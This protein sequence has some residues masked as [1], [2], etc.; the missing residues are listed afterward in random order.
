MEFGQ[1]S[2]SDFGLELK[3]AC[4][5]GGSTDAGR[6]SASGRA[7]SAAPCLPPL[8]DEQLRL[9]SLA[10]EGKNVLVDACIGS[11]KTTAIQAMCSRLTGRK[12]LYLTYNKLLKADAKAMI[13]GDHVTVTNYHGFA[14]SCLAGA[15]ISCGVSDFIRMFLAFKDR[16]R[17]PAYDMLVIDE[18]QDVD[19][20]VAAML[21]VIKDRCPGIQIIAVG[22]LE[23]KIYD[24]TSLDVMAFFNNFLGEHELLRFT[25][26]FRLSADIAA[27]LG[28]IWRKQIVG[29][30]GASRIESMGTGDVVRF[31]SEQDP[32]D[33]LC[34][35]SRSGQMAGVLNALENRYPDA[36][37]KRT[38]YASIGDHDR[39]VTPY[40][41]TA[42][43]TT[44]DSS[45]GLERRIC[46]IF[47][48]TLEYW[49]VRAEKPNVK[50][51][52]L[53]NIF[54]VAASRGK[55][56]IIFVKDGR[57][58]LSEEVLAVPRDERLEYGEPFGI[59]DMFDFKYKE[60]VEACYGMLGIR[61]LD[62]G[63]APV[64]DVRSHDCLID[65]A[66]CIGILQEASFFEGYDIDGEIAFAAKMNRG[67]SVWP[68]D[69][70][71]IEDKVLRLTAYETGHA[72]YYYQVKGPLIKEDELAMIHE[73]L[74]GTFGRREEIQ[75]ECSMEFRELRTGRT[76]MAAGRADVV[77]GGTVYELKFVSELGHEHFL[78]LACYM[79]ALGLDRGVLWNVRDGSR[80]A[81]SVPD[82]P[83]FL[84]AV[85]RTITKGSFRGSVECVMGNGAA[86][87][88]SAPGVQGAA[89]S[90]APAA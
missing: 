38:V 29:V 77:K 25:R 1:M 52:I 11:G 69:D 14:Y 67:I 61:K 56:R 71:T 10:E 3:P 79:A 88:C 81:V 17:I 50:Y 90:P 15:R 49:T 32:G 51:E 66:P 6:S 57:E 40:P 33:I 12:I 85:A 78:Q 53:R 64:I 31:L 59:S 4:A 87:M 43:F 89:G 54:C 60:D 7:G 75:T 72:R 24:W 13:R 65:L 26:C 46:V 83:R 55:E 19:G 84:G 76:A 39:S 23:Q 44:F 63:S 27:G 34:L 21:S 82:M 58:M 86:F 74:S 2:L 30:N 41:G 73:R 36:Y 62:D 45:K 16:L 68:R 42:I 80:Y 37:N 5:A 22:D 20:D 28:R 48:F 70:E 35:G 18:Y 47:D 9:I 8:S